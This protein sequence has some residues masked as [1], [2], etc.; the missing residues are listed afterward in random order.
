MQLFQGGQRGALQP[1]SSTRTR[2]SAR[3]RT[4]CGPCLGTSVDAWG[5]KAIRTKRSGMRTL[6]TDHKRVRVARLLFLSQYPA[7]AS[8]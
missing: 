8:R 2:Q 6:L 1:D 4:G 7:A 5:R 3:S